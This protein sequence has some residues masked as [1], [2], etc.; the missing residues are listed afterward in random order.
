[1][2]ILREILTILIDRRIYDAKY[3]DRSL[4]HTSYIKFQI[5]TQNYF[6]NW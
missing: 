1:M 2:F 4:I 5:P 3:E 6:K